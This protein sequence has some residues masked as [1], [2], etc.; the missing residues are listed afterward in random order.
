LGGHSSPQHTCGSAPVD[1]VRV[2]DDFTKEVKYC[3]YFNDDE[4][5]EKCTC[6]LFEFKGIMCRHALIVLTLIKC[7]EELPSKFILD[8]W[9]KDLKRK[10]TFIKSSYDD[11]SGNPKVQK[12]DDL[13]N[14]F[15]EV[16]FIASE[17]TETYM[18]MKTCVR[19]LKEELIHKGFPLVVKQLMGAL[20][21][22]ISCEVLQ[23]E[24]VKGGYHQHASSLL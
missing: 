15:S 21:Y 1:R 17:D 22:V 23:L 5:D 10:Y 11:L 7:V 12:Y 3:V 13:Y 6:R 8:R 9:R 16:A 4:C 18:K 20:R 19:K 2:N 24:K 14:D